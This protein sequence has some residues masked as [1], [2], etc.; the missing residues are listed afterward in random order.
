MDITQGQ[1]TTVLTPPH[2]II[3]DVVQRALAEDIGF[4]DL[5]SDAIVGPETQARGRIIARAEGVI[6][7]LPVSSVVFTAVDPEIRFGP[8]VADGTKVGSGDIIAHISGSARSILTAERVALNF[9]QQLSGVATLTRAIVDQIEGTN[10]QLLDTRKTVPGLRALQRYAVR[11]GGGTNHRFN[12]FDGVLIK[13]N[14]IAVAG[15]I[16]RAV[17]RARAAT[18][19]MTVI[20]VEVETLEQLDEAIA[21]GANMVLLDNMSPNE[22]AQAVE[23]AHERVRLE[24]SGDI[25]RETAR[26]VAQSGVDYF[27]S[28]ALTHSASALNLSLLLDPI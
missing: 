12:L 8:Q 25:T 14:H 13:E 11:V 17:E 5:T 4:G 16:I 22:L 15:G 18:G 20:E 7:G 9:L 23:R 26:A 1:M 19:P 10:V 21:A 6:A 2:H 3:A 27:S 24:A 28:G